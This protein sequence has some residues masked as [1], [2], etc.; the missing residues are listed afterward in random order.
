MPPKN[1]T[2]QK[3]CTFDS[4]VVLGADPSRC[5]KIQAAAKQKAKAA[6]DKTFGM[7]NKNKSKKVQ[8]YIDQVKTAGAFE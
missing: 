2:T 7:K 6:D 4:F 5:A 8:E 1:A 3:V